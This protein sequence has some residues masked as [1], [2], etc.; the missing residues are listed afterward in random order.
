MALLRECIIV[1]GKASGSHVLGKMRDR[2]YNPKLKIVRELTPDGL[3]I[4]YIEDQQTGYLEGMNANGIG[5]VNA[6]LLVSA[7]EKAAD[8]YWM[9][10][11]KKKGS[12]ND[13]P[14]VKKALELPKLSQ[15][16][17]SLV[18]YDDGLKGHTLVG[19]PTSLYSIEMT[20]QHNPIIKKLDPTTGYDVRTNHGEDHEGAGYTP[21][22]HPEDYL[23]SKIRKATAQV[24]LTGVDDAEALMP[25]IASQEFEGGSNMNMMRRTPNMR[26]SSQVLM[27]LDDLELTC[28]LF[29]GECSFSGIVDNTPDNYEPKINIVVKEYDDGKE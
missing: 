28:Y 17:K 8:Q 9:R 5:L 10:Q 23:S 15:V 19:S 26:S 16:I 1:G 14:R 11:K 22:K 6:A 21:E 12:S 24:K 27:N 2:N 25:S 18:G 3:E 7:D 29:P 13:G 20:S 4:A